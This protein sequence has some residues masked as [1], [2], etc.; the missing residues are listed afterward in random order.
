MLVLVLDKTTARLMIE[1]DTSRL[2]KKICVNMLGKTGVISLLSVSRLN[3]DL[4]NKILH[5]LISCCVY[6]VL[7]DLSI[8]VIK[9]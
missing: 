5:V 8:K 2:K 3:H 7:C 1:Y 4:V 6:F 9:M